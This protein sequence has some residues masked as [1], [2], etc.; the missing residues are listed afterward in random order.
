MS[1]SSGSPSP[2]DGPLP[3]HPSVAGPSVRR[4]ANTLDPE[5]AEANRLLH[6]PAVSPGDIRR[7][8]FLQG[9]LA[10][11][12]AAAVGLPTFSD[13]AR[14]APLRDD[15]RILVMI[16][17]SGGNDGLNT[18][19]PADTGRYY[20]LRGSMAVGRSGLHRVA[21]GTYLH[22]NLSKLKQRYDQGD[23]AII[24]GV[25]EPTD[26][27]S[28]FVSMARWMAGTAAPQPWYTGWLGRY[29]DGIGA[30]ELAGVSI[31]HSGSPLLLA[32]A[33]GGSTSIPPYAGLF[34][35]DRR[36]DSTNRVLYDSLLELQAGNIGKGPVAR[37]VATDTKSAIRT[38]A[39]IGPMF[40]DPD[41][42]MD[43]NDQ[44]VIDATLVAR[45]INLD[46][47]ARVITI[48]LG[49][50]DHHENQRPE[51][52]RFMASLDNAIDRIFTRV[53]PRFRDRL[54]VMTYSEFGRRVQPTSSGTDHGTAGPMICVGAGVRG[55]LYG[56]APSLGSLD[57]RGDLRHQVDFRS[58]Y[59]TV[60][61]DWLDADSTEVLGRKYERLGFVAG[62]TGP[63]CM[64]VPATIVGTAGADRLVGTSG[65][66]VIVARGGD[67]VIRGGGG[68]DLICA[69]DGDDTVYGG[70]GRDVVHG[71]DGSDEIEG[72]GGRDKLFGGSGGDSLRGGG[73]EDVLKGGAGRDRLWGGKHRDTLNGG[74]GADEIHG[75]RRLD[76]I[77]SQ[78]VD[79]ILD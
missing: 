79:R 55:G 10:V 63:S 38:A 46:L 18:V 19:V 4:L 41:P 51:H 8:R 56:Q 28:H 32:R 22:P 14:A 74:P 67:D 42:L 33:A 69:G 27:H 11:G 40:P 36:T 73:R 78:A 7:R 29:L 35:M 59:A 77:V 62:S 21:P 65:R 31:G 12:G 58:V 26:D 66:D 64:G 6:A 50:F 15:E 37:R 34:G 60:L 30:D 3:V 57:E 9:M 45:L 61:E 71:Q 47:G 16:L 54:M 72:N 1:H 25:G 76:D 23:V 53:K 24:E 2:F 20:D 39:R 44:F 5:L 49:G 70:A 43:H 17:L 52:D 13:S 48:S 75:S 68:N